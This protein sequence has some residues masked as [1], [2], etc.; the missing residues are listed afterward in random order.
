MS[1]G[2]QLFCGQFF[3]HKLTFFDD[4]AGYTSRG[5][6][7]IVSCSYSLHQVFSVKSLQQLTDSKYIMKYCSRMP[8]SDI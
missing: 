4:P 8:I 2:V 6:F 7:G 1:L 3:Q 5:C